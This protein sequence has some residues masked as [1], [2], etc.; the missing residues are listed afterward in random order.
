[1]VSQAVEALGW[2]L[3]GLG[4]L[5]AARSLLEEGVAIARTR[6]DRRF[7]ARGLNGLGAVQAQQG[8]DLA[9]QA[10]LAEALAYAI[11]LGDRWVM[12]ACL[13]DLADL[14]ADRAEWVQFA[15]LY[16]ATEALSGGLR[17]NRPALYASRGERASQVARAHLGAEAYAA[18]QAEGARLA[19]A[20]SPQAWD[21]LL[22]AELPEQAAAPA[23]SLSERERDVV[24]LLVEG[25][26]NAQIAERLVV[27]PFT[28]NAHL[29]N[30]YGKLGL[31]SRPALIRHAIEHG[32][33]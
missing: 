25:L 26:T 18:A 4:E 20:G 10:S 17:A 1:V 32:L 6:G 21:A 16:G 23:A 9:A 33:V 22:A 27:S 28:V 15:R 29:R 13:I 5:A 24:R 12:V 11:E 31:P 7:L 14:A 30:I 8:A 3:F 2:T 19:A